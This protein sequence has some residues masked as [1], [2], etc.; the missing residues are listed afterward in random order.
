[1]LL[2]KKILFLQLKKFYELVKQIGTI[3]HYDS[4]ISNATEEVLEEIADSG[5]YEYSGNKVEIKEDVEIS[6]ET[7]DLLSYLTH[8]PKTHN[9]GINMIISFL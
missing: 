2:T 8:K 1:M 5:F 3:W 7:I 4:T 6:Q 9:N